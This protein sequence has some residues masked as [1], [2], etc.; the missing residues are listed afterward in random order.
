MKKELHESLTIKSAVAICVLVL[1]KVLLPVFT[2][3]EVPDSL[4][5]SVCA[6]LGVSVTVG[7]RRALPV[8]IVG[9]LSFS[10]IQCGPSVCQKA[11]IEITKHPE[12]PSPA[13]TITVKCD[14]KDKAVLHG[15][16]LV[17]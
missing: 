2:N 15:K 14:G 5:E 11:T 13:A 7:M 4:F 10:T 12:L 9:F 3:Y 16:E 1:A 6:V 17:K 8:L